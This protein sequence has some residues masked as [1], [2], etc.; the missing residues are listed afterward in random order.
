MKRTAISPLSVNSTLG[1]LPYCVATARPVLNAIPSQPKPTPRAAARFT[2]AT[3]PTGTKMLHEYRDGVLVVTYDGVQFNALD[4]RLASNI[5]V[6]FTEG[7]QVDGLRELGRAA[8]DETSRELYTVLLDQV[9]RSGDAA[10][11]IGRAAE[12]FGKVRAEAGE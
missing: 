11:V 6:D 5:F 10:G 2:Q 12:L 9:D 8:E 4:A 1:H 7:A 3:L